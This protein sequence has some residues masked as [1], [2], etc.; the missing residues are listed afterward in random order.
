MDENK[1]KNETQ[2]Q[3][4][5]SQGEQKL[6]SCSDNPGQKSAKIYCYEILIKNNPT[7]KSHG[8]KKI[9]N[10]LMFQDLF[11]IIRLENTERINLERLFQRYEGDYLLKV[12]CLLEK[13]ASVKNIKPKENKIKLELNLVLDDVK[14]IYKYKL[15]NWIRNPYK[16]KELIKIFYPLISE[17]ILSPVELKLCDMVIN[18]N[19]AD[20]EYIRSFF[21]VSIEEY[22]Q[23]LRLIISFLCFEKDDDNTRLDEF[24]RNFFFAKELMTIIFIFSYDNEHP[25]LP[26]VGLVRDPYD[27]NHPFYMNIS[28]SC[29]I[30]LQ[31]TVIESSHFNK[32]LKNNNF[33][34]EKI[35]QLK[36]ELATSVRATLYTNELEVLAGYNKICVGASNSQVFSASP[37][38]YGVTVV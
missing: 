36:E 33:S 17:C 4:F 35:S 37:N 26:D 1:F 13:I 16:I 8:K 14:F 31:H 24:V 2:I 27:E 6:N 12:E 32:F 21:G 20:S 7:I 29:F 25:L 30:A 23:W 3:H 38:V 19:D 34:M 9:Q 22:K 10:T 5:V 11:T 28:K 15:M 18:K